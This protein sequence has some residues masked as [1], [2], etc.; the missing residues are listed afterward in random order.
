MGVALKVIVAI[1]RRRLLQKRSVSAWFAKVK[2]IDPF[3]LVMALDESSQV[4]G[5]AWQFPPHDKLVYY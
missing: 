1:P 3:E 4:G 5:K 2:T